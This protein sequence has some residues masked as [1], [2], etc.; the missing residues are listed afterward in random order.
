MCEEH[1]VIQ[2][3]R[4]I[5]CIDVGHTPAQ[6]LLSVNAYFLGRTMGL[7]LLSVKDMHGMYTGQT[8]T[9]RRKIKD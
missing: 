3:K 6:V 8:R 1:R 4:N 7:M 9:D 2:G 5:L